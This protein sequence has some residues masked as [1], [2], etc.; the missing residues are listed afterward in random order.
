MLGSLLL[1]ALILSLLVLDPGSRQVASILALI[2][3]TALAAAGAFALA[4]PDPEY[5][6]DK[7]L[8]FLSAHAYAEATRDRTAL[9]AAIGKAFCEKRISSWATTR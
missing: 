4:M 2:G 8:E 6:N 5:M 9:Q 7:Q 3:L 1:L